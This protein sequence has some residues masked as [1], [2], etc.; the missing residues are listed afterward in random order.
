MAMVAQLLDDPIS[1][2]GDGDTDA[3]EDLSNQSENDGD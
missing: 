3:D 1:E 2:F